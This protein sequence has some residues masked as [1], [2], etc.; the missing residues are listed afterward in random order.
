MFAMNK[1][2]VSEAVKICSSLAELARRIGVTKAAV[3]QWENKTKV[4]AARCIDIERATG[5][6]VTCEQLRPDLADRWS[7]LRGTESRAA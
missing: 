4:P 1:N 5:G 2:P 3:W 6:A 7:Y